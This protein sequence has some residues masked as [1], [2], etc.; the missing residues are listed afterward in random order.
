MYLAKLAISNF[1]KL[2]N[3]EVSFRPGL[4]VVIGPNNVGK[5]AV[6][7]ALR[8]LLAGA[9]DPYPRFTIDDVHCPKGGKPSGP[10]TFV[11]TFCDLTLDDEA[12]FMSALKPAAGGLLEAQ[13][14]VRYADP[15]QAGRLRVKRWCGNN[16]D[17]PLTSDMME[18]LRGVYLP[19]LRD[20][21]QGLKPSRTSQLSRLL[22]LLSD[23]AGRDLINEELEKLD[24]ALKTHAPLVLT[25][26]SIVG[27]HKSM[28]GAQLAQALEIGLSASDFQ[29]LA[30]RTSLLVDSLEI[31]HNGLGFNNLI[32]MAVV[33]SELAK[34]PE[35]AFRGLIVEEPEAHLHPQLQSVLLNYLSSIHLDQGEKAVQ[36]FVTSH[37]P[38]FASGAKLDTLVCLVET[39]SGVRTFSPGH[40]SF[41][42]S[43]REKLERYL[44]VTRAELFFAGRVIFVEGAG[45]RMLISVLAEKAG[46]SLREHAVSLISVDGLNFDSFLPLFGETALNVPVA[47]ITDADPPAVEMVAEQPKVAVYPASG[48]VVTL[49]DNTAAM[50]KHEDTFVKVFHGVK[51]FEYDLALHP[52]LRP[53]MIAAL[54]ELKPQVGA[55]LEKA[56]DAEIGDAAKA[57]TLFKGMFERS[58]NNVQK[59]SFGQALAAQIADHDGA[60]P[61]PPYILAAIKHACQVAVPV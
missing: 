12:D 61:C 28:L 4:N 14:S 55:D 43:K 48:D 49:S 40:V 16:D 8:A 56:V 46:Y 30:A 60:L 11:Y 10:I 59:G 27:R 18:N 52:E 17:V 51:T 33:L 50:K 21:A 5:T 22:H 57:K 25:E 24:K 38:N 39:A 19:P 9:D 20:A 41:G 31:E 54:K 37:S 13:I 29:K 26:Q 23:Q 44:D 34:N 2:K 53:L 58:S 35:A 15:D 36:V 45:E 47:A 42:P 6:V 3:V 32:F 7:D 1:R